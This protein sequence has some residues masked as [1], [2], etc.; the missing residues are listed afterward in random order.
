MCFDTTTSNTGRLNGA[1]TILEQMLDKELFYFAC[2]H[3]ILEVLLR[4]VFDGKLGSTTGPHP[5]LLKKIEKAWPNIDKTKYDLGI[6]NKN[7]EKHITSQFITDITADFKSKLAEF[8]PRDDYKELLELVL[9]FIGTLDGREVGFK[10]PGAISHARWMAKAIYCL[11]IYLFRGQ[12]QLTVKE[13]SALEAIC[14]FLVRIYCQAWFNSP[15]AHMAPYQDLKLLERLIEFQDI[16]KEIAERGLVKFSNH[17]W[18]F[19]SELVALALFD[20]TL[21]PEEKSRLPEKII[22]TAGSDENEQEHSRIIKPI[23]QRQQMEELV[24]TGL[25]SLI[26]KET[27]RFL[28]RFDIETSFLKEPPTGWLENSHYNEG[29]RIVKSLKVVND[30]A[31]RG[32]KLI[33]DFNKL[34]T[35]DEDQK[36][37][38]LQVVA[39]CRKLYP[40]ASKSTLCK[41]L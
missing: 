4:G 35:K 14:I 17:L 8:Q 34:L 37:F 33:T 5:D 30:C 6:S 29:L 23:M 36:Q 39:E 24:R 2:R 11:K 20:P 26:T 7:V 40:D 16:D 9:V 41:P 10:T 31:E 32:V 19:N 21:P 1:C 27:I 22:A 38:V 12:F 18:Y 25:S 3:H 28:D 15:K 13:L